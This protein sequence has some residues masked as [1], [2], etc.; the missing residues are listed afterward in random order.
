MITTFEFRRFGL[1]CSMN[2]I[3]ISKY[4]SCCVLSFDVHKLLPGH[5][6]AQVTPESGDLK[7]FVDLKLPVIAPD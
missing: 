1:L 5:N 4:R 2:L 6:H 7:I 3:Y